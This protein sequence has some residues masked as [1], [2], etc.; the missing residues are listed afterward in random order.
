VNDGPAAIEAAAND[1][2]KPYELVA[3][4][5][6]SRRKASLLEAGTPLRRELPNEKF[7]VVAEN[8]LGV[9]VSTKESHD[10]I[11]LGGIDVSLSESH[12]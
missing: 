4:P 10:F 5:K 9:P 2:K 1:T 11:D 12:G 6:C 3:I 8:V 7:A